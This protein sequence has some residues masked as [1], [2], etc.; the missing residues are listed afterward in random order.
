MTRLHSPALSSCSSSSSK[1]STSRTFRDSRKRTDSQYSSSSTSLSAAPHSKDPNFL[2]WRPTVRSSR[3]S[4]TSTVSSTTSTTDSEN[5]NGNSVDKSR[6]LTTTDENQQKNSLPGRALPKIT[7]RMRTDPI[8]VDKIG[9]I[10]SPKPAHAPITLEN[11]KRSITEPS[12]SES[13]I[14]S[15]NKRRKV[16]S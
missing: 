11:G 2:L 10:N 14:L 5:L 9:Q 7:I 1:S 6:T 16:Q 3:H 8:L 4:S 12:N 15:S 13:S